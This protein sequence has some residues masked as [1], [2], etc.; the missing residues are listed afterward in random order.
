[1]TKRL[2]TFIIAVFVFAIGFLF[3]KPHS[4]MAANPPV[5]DLTLELV[6]RQY[7]ITGDQKPD[8]IVV[9]YYRGI[10]SVMINDKTYYTF[11]MGESG[12]VISKI[13]TLKNGTPILYL[14]SPDIN[15][16]GTVCGLFQF[17][18]GKLVQVADLENLLKKGYES[19][20]EVLKVKGNTITAQVFIM[21][22]T[23]GVS[24]YE[25]DYVY[26]NGTLKPKSTIGRVSKIFSQGGEVKKLT[27]NRKINVYSSA[28]AT[29]KVFTLKKG[30]K[31][32][33][34]KIYHG[35]YGEWIR[36]KFKGKTGWMKCADSLQITTPKYFSNIMYAG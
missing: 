21:S 18:S 31:V 29:K 28:K 9:D 36:I 12:E 30:N 2:K 22:Y 14:Y 33:V 16:Y 35:A 6:Y 23:L 19:Y 24:Y 17:K 13:Y 20:G 1:M 15:Y 26:K 10:V 8:V 7:D 4:V 25:F 32:V 34:D 11:K 5:A 27:V 3:M